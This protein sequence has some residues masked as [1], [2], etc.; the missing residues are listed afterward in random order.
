MWGIFSSIYILNQFEVPAWWKKTTEA[1]SL[2][3]AQLGVR[4]APA[5]QSA[6]AGRSEAAGGFTSE[7][8]RR[9]G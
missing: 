3:P 7:V 6:V 5:G 4:C 8:V 9:G 2:L 1:G